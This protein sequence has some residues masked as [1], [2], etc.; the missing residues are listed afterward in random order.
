MGD[1]VNKSAKRSGQS[2]LKFISIK[3]PEY[4]LEF[5]NGALSNVTPRG[6]IVCH[7]YF[8]SRDMPTEQE[9]MLI[10]EDSG[11][12]KLSPFQD[13]RTYTRDVKF[14]IVI[15]VPFAKDLV[16]MLN[17]KITECE[18]AAAEGANICK[19]E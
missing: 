9:A 4:G 3:S 12:A 10:N 2:K 11:E 6:E 8:E 5:I 13:P 14:G 17:T 16:K 15:N 18:S 7:F 1:D 19:P